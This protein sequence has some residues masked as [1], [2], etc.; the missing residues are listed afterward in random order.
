MTFN[1][2]L[3][4]LHIYSNRICWWST[5]YNTS[6]TKQGYFRQKYLRRENWIH[7][8]MLWSFQCFFFWIW[9]HKIKQIIRTR[10]FV[11]K[12]IMKKTESEKVGRKVHSSFLVM[13]RLCSFFLL[14]RSL[15]PLFE[16]LVSFQVLVLLNSCHVIWHLKIFEKFGVVTTTF[17]KFSLFISHLRLLL[18]EARDWFG[19]SFVWYEKETELQQ[20]RSVDTSCVSL[21]HYSLLG[22]L[23]SITK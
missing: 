23:I 18:T 21:L 19:F 14:L 12:K 22:N 16:S 6:T 5:S 13:T 15:V 1:L 11:C 9:H 3:R 20:W 7:G 10:I 2:E 8:P 17:F 4:P